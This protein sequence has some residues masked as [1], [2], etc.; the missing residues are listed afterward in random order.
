MAGRRL[1][2]AEV[3]ALVVLAAADFWAIRS[4]TRD[5][6]GD[7]AWLLCDGAVPM[8]KVGCTMIRSN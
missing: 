3:M 7:A 8:L 4:I 6:G 2:I 5:E 1:A